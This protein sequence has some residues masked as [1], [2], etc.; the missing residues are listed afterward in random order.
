MR[1]ARRSLQVVNRFEFHVSRKAR[2][3]YNFDEQLF[4]LNGNVVLA[5]FA[6]CPAFCRE[7]DK[8]TRS[9]RPRQ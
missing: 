2:E 6:R 5:D 3:K 8:S 1:V 7:H 9:G 4:A